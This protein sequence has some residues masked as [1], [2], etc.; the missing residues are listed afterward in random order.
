MKGKIEKFD[1][2][3]GIISHITLTNE[4]GASVT[5]STLGAGIV[6]IKVPD[7]EGKLSDIVM[8]YKNPCDYIYDGPCCGKI[9]GRYANRIA[10][11]LFFLNDKEYH[12]NINCGPNHLHGGPEGIQ[13]QNWLYAVDGEAGDVTFFLKSKDGDEYYPGN[14]EIRANYL[15][16]ENNEL[17]L[18]LQ[19]V[20]DADT[21]LNLTNHTYFCLSG[22]NAGNALEHELQLFCS[23]Y[24]D[25]DDSLAPTGKLLPVKGTPM[26]FTRSHP[27]KDR[28]KDDFKPLHIGKG[29]DHCWVA[30]GFSEKA[31]KLNI[32]AILKDRNSGRQLQIDSTQPGVQ[33]YTGNWL[34]GSPMGKDDYEY[35]DY[36]CVAIECQGLPD[37]PNHK[38][39]PSQILR[40]GKE[41]YQQI[42]FRFTTLL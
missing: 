15:W 3:K 34:T 25:T 27:I 31:P 1:S 30:D 17:H 4:S 7:A 23:K 8:G 2:H 6:S 38:N 10:R 9:P 33:V 37:A 14:I 21:I 22:H 28:I 35:K 40:P 39:F 42:I 32:I 20:T 29:Y 41:Y 18:T 26:D 16:T 24:L 13:N 5:L 19:A 11:G 12:L 36:D